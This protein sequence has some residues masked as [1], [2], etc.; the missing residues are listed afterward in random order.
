MTYMQVAVEGGIPSLILYLLIFR[1]GFR[2][3]REL[4]KRKDLLVEDEV[5]RGAMHSSFVGFMVGALFSPEAYHFFPYFAVAYTSAMLVMFRRKD[6]GG[7]PTPSSNGR[8][9]RPLSIYGAYEKRQPQLA[10]PR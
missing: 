7:E 9:R 5:F 1:I 10:V 3:L 4:G 6:T 8:R 2:N